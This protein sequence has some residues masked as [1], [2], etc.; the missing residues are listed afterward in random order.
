MDKLYLNE[1]LSDCKVCAV[2]KADRM[3]TQVSKKVQYRCRCSVNL[4]ITIV[5]SYRFRSME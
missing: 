1:S 4:M 3:E 2:V 5:R